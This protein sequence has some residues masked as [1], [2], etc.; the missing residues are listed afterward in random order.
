ME[1]IIDI[2]EAIKELQN[3][4][5][6]IIFDKYTENEGDLCY[7]S[8]IINKEIIKFMMNECKGIICQTLPEEHIRKLEIPV[9]QKKRNNQNNFNSFYSKMTKF[10]VKMRRKHCKHSSNL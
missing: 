6:I 4:R 9:F 8:E 1:N 10:T 5:P 3:Q 7:P 2:H